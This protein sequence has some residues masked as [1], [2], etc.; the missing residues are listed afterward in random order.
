MTGCPACD[1]M[2][3]TKHMRIN[4]GPRLWNLQSPSY[5]LNGKIEGTIALSGEQD[6]V[7]S[8]TMTLEGR[9]RTTLSQR[10]AMS[11]DSLLT[12]L[13]H[14]ETI[15]DASKT[16]SFSWEEVHSFCLS[17]PREAKFQGQLTTLPPSHLSYDQLATTDVFYTVK[18]QMNRRNKGIKKQE[19]KVVRILYLPKSTPSEPPVHSIPRPS[20]RQEANE[21]LNQLERVKTTA[22]T[23]YHP[24]DSKCKAKR[25]RTP[26]EIFNRNVFLSVPDPQCYASGQSIPFTLSLVFPDDPVIPHLLTRNMRIQVLKRLI[27][28]KKTSSGVQAVQRDSFVSSAT[29]R[30]GREYTEGVTLLKGEIK[31][32]EPGKEVSWK[33]DAVAEVQ[34]VLRILL[35]PPNNLVGF[36]PSFRHEEVIKIT[37]DMWGIL[38]RE[39]SSTGGTPTPAIG[40]A[41][42]LRRDFS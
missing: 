20:R 34:Y 24:P 21:F 8:V 13:S 38:D 19:T 11:A 31:A 6:R 36:V 30:Y 10:S 25:S 18:F 3:D 15:Y 28:W 29:L 9:I 4:M 23:P 27:V 42:S 12:L 16:N 22:L 33:L 37:T 17:I 14:T 26:L 35:K 5:G 41:A 2:F 7:E 39:L 40:L 32:G 1:W